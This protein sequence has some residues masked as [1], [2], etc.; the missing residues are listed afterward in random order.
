MLIRS[1]D[2]SV[3]LCYRVLAEQRRYRSNDDAQ[4]RW[5]QRDSGKLWFSDWDLSCC[6]PLRRPV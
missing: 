3:Q 2:Y 6:R 5:V 4:G 1:V